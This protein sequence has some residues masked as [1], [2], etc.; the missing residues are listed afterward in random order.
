VD[1][2]DIDYFTDES[3]VDDPYP[4]LDALR[5][6]CPVHREPHHGVMAV[7]GYQEAA[8]VY[9]SHE[10]YSS[11]NSVAGPYPGVPFEPQGDDV[12]D[13]IARHRSEF[14]MSEHMVTFDDP[15]HAEHRALLMRLLTPRRL[16]ENEG[17]VWEL[18][19]RQI[20]EFL[21]DG[22]CEFLRAYGRPLALLSIADLL[23]V[24]EEDREELRTKLG[25]QRPGQHATDDDP[26]Y[27]H[28][29]LLYLEDR[30]SEYVEQ[31]RA[32]P[33]D[34][35]LT[36]LASARFRNGSLPEVID[37]VRLATFLFAAGQD[38]TARL[39]SAAMFIIAENP[40]LQEQLRTDRTKIPDFVEEVLR[41]E[42]P[43][44]TDFRLARRTTDLAGVE[45][46]AGTMVMILNG[47]A[48]RDPD[49]FDDPHEFRP[50]R[51][52]ARDHLAFG[53]GIH[54]CPGAPL[55]RV[56]AR[57]SLERILD[58]MVDI[59]IADAEHGPPTARRFSYEPTYLLRGVTALHV[60]FDPVR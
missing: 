3:I 31:R 13:L 7:S 48:N 59:R 44:K 34:D 53:R 47:A 56:E 18:A 35:V 10:T 54:F 50:D 37:V 60:E 25:A 21:D 19:D 23:G 52:N 43:V 40:Q 46:P 22:H 57:V 58:R 11:C 8:E 39:L 32:E 45:I 9:R 14:A 29:P 15:E 20:D 1:V 33:R 17:F 30:F 27:R 2:D 16:E 6:R 12:S 41:V 4:Y 55:A 38:T 5:S 51:P 42:S 24:P 49:R 26:R 28:N 36:K